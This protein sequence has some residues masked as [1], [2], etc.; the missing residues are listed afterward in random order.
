M[1][2]IDKDL[3]TVSSKDGS[4]R[5]VGLGTPEGFQILTKLWLRSGWDT[6]YVYSFTWLGRPIIQLPDDLIRLQEVIYRIKPDVIIDVGI[7]HGGSLV[8][9]AGLCRVIGKG[10]V[11]GIDI[12]IRAHNRSA[13]EQHELAPLITMIEGDSISPD[14]LRHVT[15]LIRPGEVVLACLDGCHTR[16]HVHA[17]LET[18]GPLISPNSYVV[19]MDGIMKDL[20]GAPRSQPD[21]GINNPMQAVSDFLARHPEFRLEE[22]PIPFNEGAITERVT[23]WP[24]AF[25]RRI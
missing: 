7:A 18:Y 13:V 17:E 22:P 20:V 8:F 11:I 4:S 25:L 2:T 6:K 19:A 3:I 9:S 23:Y 1:I 21:W 10:R 14:V 15:S 12:E 5:T 24:N 16:E